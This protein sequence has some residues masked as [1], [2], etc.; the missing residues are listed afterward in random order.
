MTRLICSVG[1]K[2]IKVPIFSTRVSWQHFVL[3][4]TDKSAFGEEKTLISIYCKTCIIPFTH[5]NI[6]FACTLTRSSKTR[7]ADV[8]PSS[9]SSSSSF[10]GF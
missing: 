8:H 6:Y 9:S 5:P 2:K 3:A 7:F 4:R 1:E 10:L